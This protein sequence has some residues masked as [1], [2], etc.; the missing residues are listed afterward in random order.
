VGNLV[1]GVIVLL[2]GLL[3][4]WQPR[5]ISSAT[6]K[7]DT[8]MSPR[9]APYFRMSPQFIRIIGILFMAAG[10]LTIMYSLLAR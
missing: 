1:L 10:A 5:R 9:L 6:H 7:W 4:T 8:K 2:L 3:G